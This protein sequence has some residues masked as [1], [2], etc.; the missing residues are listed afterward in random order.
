[1]AFKIKESSDRTVWAEFSDGFLVEIRHV[2]QADMRKIREQS[3]V[4]QWDP[5]THQRVEEA[6]TQKFYEL[7]GKRAIVTWKGLTGDL[8]R[9]WVDMDEY[10]EGEVP[11]SSE[12]AAELLLGFGRFDT[13]VTMVSQDLEAAEAVRKA[14]VVKNSQPTP[15]VPSNSVAV[16]VDANGIAKNA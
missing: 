7:F 11:Y 3:Q 5:K 4:R 12:T 16:A 13:F 10:P 14:T 15:G 9:A 1:M 8:L 6:D 2:T